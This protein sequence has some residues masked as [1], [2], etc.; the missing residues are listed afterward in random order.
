MFRRKINLGHFTEA[1]MADAL[2][3]RAGALHS[4]FLTLLG[5]TDALVRMAWRML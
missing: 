2:Q 3:G 5:I 1:M 4:L